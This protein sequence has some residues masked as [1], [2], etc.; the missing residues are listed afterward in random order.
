LEWVLVPL[1]A[2]VDGFEG[3]ED[4]VE[5][6][7]EVGV[8]R[9]TGSGG[10]FGFADVGGLEIVLE[11]GVVGWSPLELPTHVV[12]VSGGPADFVI[13][14]GLQQGLSCPTS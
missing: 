6:I 10:V 2:V 9:G 1:A 8:E 12:R 13:T 7:L 3:G 5:Y 4:A 14:K 11:V